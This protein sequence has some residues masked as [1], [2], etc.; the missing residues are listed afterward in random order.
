MA[1]ETKDTGS[2]RRINMAAFDIHSMRGDFREARISTMS[3]AGG[4]SAE[5]ARLDLA[6]ARIHAEKGQTL[7]AVALLERILS[8]YGVDGP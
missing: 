1:K 3:G 7:E 2:E 5:L 6:K 4:G 8:E